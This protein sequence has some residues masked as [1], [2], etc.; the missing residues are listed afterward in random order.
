MMKRASIAW[1]ASLVLVLGSCAGKD[2]LD[3]GG[4][5]GDDSHGGDGA[6]AGEGGASSS[7]AGGDGGADTSGSG[8]GSTDGGASVVPGNEFPCGNSVCSPPNVCCWQFP[9]TATCEAP[10]QCNDVAVSCTSTTCPAG[11]LCCV[12]IQG[13]MPSNDYTGW[14]R[15][16]ETAT[17]P[18]ATQPACVQTQSGG[19]PQ[20]DGC[21]MG[22]VCDGF[23][24]GL[25]TCAP[26]NGQVGTGG[27]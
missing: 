22:M 10:G 17:C 18:S 23:A 8:G 27:D 14:A 16:L 15:C 24:L 26:A 7:G 11:S 21:P 25:T 6:A 4:D 2:I 5:A 9:A 12:S 13:T 1:L 20:Q 3:L 19:A